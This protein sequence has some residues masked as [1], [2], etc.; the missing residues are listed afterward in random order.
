MIGERAARQRR[1]LKLTQRTVAEKM[2]VTSDTISRIERG[3]HTPEFKQVV[4]L[5]HALNVTTDYLMGLVDQPHE[6]RELSDLE[7]RIIEAY[8][9]GNPIIKQAIDLAFLIQDE[10]QRRNIADTDAINH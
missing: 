8:R 7:W 10:R 1:E 4:G 9:S 3:V 6:T 5:A 2:G